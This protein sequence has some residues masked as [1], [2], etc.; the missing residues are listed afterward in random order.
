MYLPSRSLPRTHL[1]FEKSSLSLIDDEH[2][3]L[4]VNNHWII[5]NVIHFSFQW[6]FRQFLSLFFSM[7][8]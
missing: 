4:L 3:Q 8:F 6:V 7:N 2:M 5:E 1:M